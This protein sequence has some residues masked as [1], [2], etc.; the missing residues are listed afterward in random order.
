MKDKFLTTGI[1]GTIVA[2]ICCFTP[3]L[4]WSP[5]AI[6]LSAELAYL[7]FVLLPALIVFVAMVGV[8][9]WRHKQSR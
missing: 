8:V 1:V 5:A 6:G 3:L 7:D 2:A 9:L 4:A